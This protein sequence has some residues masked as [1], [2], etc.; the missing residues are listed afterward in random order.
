M[1]N[2]LPFAVSSPTSITKSET[3]TFPISLPSL[4]LSSDATVRVGPG[5]S[6]IL[7]TE[8]RTLGSVQRSPQTLDRT[9]G[10]GSVG[11]VQGQAGLEPE[12][13]ANN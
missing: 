4:V 10:S 5:H 11:S 13:N 7:R 2:N 12:P 3:T 8:N 6:Q 1:L 9:W